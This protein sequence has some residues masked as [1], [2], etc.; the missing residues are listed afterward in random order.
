MKRRDF[1]KNMTF[2]ATGLAALIIMV[3]SGCS[4]P[5]EPE[6]FI[7]ID[8]KLQYSAATVRQ[9]LAGLSVEEGFPRRVNQ[10][11]YR[12]SNT[13]YTGWTSGFFPGLLWNLYTFTGDDELKQAAIA[14]TNALEPITRMD[15]NTHDLGFMMYLSAGKAYEHTQDAIYRQWLMETADSLADLFNPVVGTIHSWPWGERRHG[16]PHNTIIDNMLNLEL[17]FWAANNGG[18]EHLRDIAITHTHTTLRNGFRNDFSTWHVI[19]YEKDSPNVIKK[20]TDQGY[21]DESVWSRGQAWAMHGFS[22]AYRET[23][24]AEFLDVAV[25]ASEF[26]IDHLPDDFVPYWDF[27]LPD[28]AGQPRDASAAAIAASALVELSTLV[29]DQEVSSHFLETAQ[30]MIRS[31][32]ENYRSEETMAILGHSTGSKPH[33]SEIDVPLVYAD[34]YFIEALMRMRNGELRMKN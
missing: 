33:D 24:I 25:A 22:M 34:Y 5:K 2:D 28:T 18:G 1:L 16:W 27:M 7:D 13:R 19:V 14:Y 9:S 3:I 20:I 26:F 30:Q 6:I 31:L 29:D 8:K 11:E 12:W 17:L 23:G 32:F 21:S 15:W 4:G 10:G